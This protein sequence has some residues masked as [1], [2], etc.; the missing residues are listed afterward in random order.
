MR[1]LTPLVAAQYGAFFLPR[2]SGPRPGC[3]WS[4]PTGTAPG[5]TSR[6][7]FKLGEALVGQAAKERR[8]IL[9]PQAPAGLHPGASGLGGSTPASI[10]VLPM[11]FEDQV[12]G[13]IELASLTPFT[14]V[15]LAFLD[16]LME[17]IGVSLNAILASS[18]TEEL[19][20]ESQRL[21][22]SCRRSRP[23][24]SRS[25]RRW[26]SGPSSSRSPAATSPSSWPT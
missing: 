18:R 14:E 12:L 15:H 7:L 20:A 6:P 21:P 16:Q 4:R 24:C 19:L 17:P 2:G 22:P 11:P 26:R 8:R 5:T 13:V 3:G 9:I 10:V 23:S 1:E 25:R